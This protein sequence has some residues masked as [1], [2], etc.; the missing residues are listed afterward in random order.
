MNYIEYRAVRI[1][2]NRCARMAQLRGCPKMCDAFF[3]F[4]PEP[5]ASSCKKVKKEWVRECELRVQ[6][7]DE[8][9]RGEMDKAAITQDKLDGL[10]DDL[11]SRFGVT[12]PAPVFVEPEVVAPEVECARQSVYQARYPT[13]PYRNKYGDEGNF[14]SEAEISRIRISLGQQPSEA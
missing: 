4:W 1:Q 13:N 12:A 2:E 14:L 11:E 8:T 6:L 5:E 10:Y 7:I 9:N 3:V